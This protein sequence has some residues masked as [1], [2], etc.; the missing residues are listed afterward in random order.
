MD[1]PEVLKRQ[2]VKCPQ[3][4]PDED[5]R[6]LNRRISVVDSDCHRCWGRGEHNETDDAYIT[7]LQRIIMELA[8]DVLSCSLY[9]EKCSGTCAYWHGKEPCISA[10]IEAAGRKVDNVDAPDWIAEKKMF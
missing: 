1:E 2:R 6:C 10:R 8:K 7:R 3:Y 9:D 5:G 4:E